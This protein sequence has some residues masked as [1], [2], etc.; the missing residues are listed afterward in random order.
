MNQRHHLLQ[1]SGFFFTLILCACARQAVPTGGPK[2]A[3]PPK[4]DTLTSTR[5]FSTRFSEKRIE[6]VFDEWV[7]L[8]DVGTQVVVSPTLAKRPELRLKGKKV[9][10]ELPEEDTLRANT[11]YTINFGTAVKDLHEGN[12]AENLRFVF[13]TGDYLDSLSV[14]GLVADAF[15]GEPVDKISVMLYETLTDSVVRKERP[16]YFARTNKT[17]Q[18][19]IQNVRPGN[20]KVAAID[21]TSGDL[22]WDGQNERIGFPDAHLSVND[23]A[24]NPVTLKLFKNQAK[25]RLV[26]D[27]TIRFGLQKLIFT[28][29]PDSVPLRFDAPNLTYLTEK[30]QDT[31]LVWY[32]M[33]EPAG[34]QL[35]IEEDTVPVKNLSRED[36]FK[37][38]RLVLADEAPVGA[39]AGKFAARPAAAPAASGPKPVKNVSL[40][41]A[42]AA[43][44]PF[45]TPVSAVDTSKWSFFLD[46][47]RVDHYLARPDSAALRN[48]RIQVDWKPG[49]SYK[50]TLLPGAVTDFYGVANADTL[51][52]VINVLGEKQLGSLTLTL[53]NLTPRTRYVLQIL[54]GANVEE[55]RFFDAVLTDKKFTFNNL[56][57]ATYTARLIGD[58]NGNGR[59]DS[60]D[61]FARRQPEPVFTKKLDPLRANWELEA[62]MRAGVS[63]SKWDAG[64]KK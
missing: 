2:D 44:L 21:D 12:P 49:K 37:N 31:L 55:E 36:F 46:S 16:Y 64:K 15:S 4:V 19:S 58:Y 30:I 29:P 7:T 38:H 13:S 17:G 26:D 28:A 62:S 25:R 50:L 8:S 63:D 6:L 18:F 39:S 57:A 51:Q 22:K 41:P 5:N 35:F 32:D 20:Y 47:T 9:I 14:S 59:W 40:S 43:F 34:W 11:T 54:N 23:T 42:K 24:K 1:L 52:R 60:G 56:Q 3:T 48:V 27:K 10:I 45:N 33:P 61:Y 53:E